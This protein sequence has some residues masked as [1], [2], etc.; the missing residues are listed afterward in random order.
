MSLAHELRQAVPSRPM[1]EL[2]ADVYDTLEFIALMYGGIG[3]GSYWSY[4]WLGADNEPRPLCVY[5]LAIEATEQD[6]LS[7][8]PFRNPVAKALAA[9]GISVLM[10][11]TAVKDILERREISTGAARVPFEDW[12]AELGVVRGE[13]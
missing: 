11:D 1:R 3:R 10:N 9:V 7:G 13:T 4:S 2:P 5:G 12:C 8:N 6:G